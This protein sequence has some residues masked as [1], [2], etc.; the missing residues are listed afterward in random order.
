MKP[1]LSA[2]NIS[3]SLSWRQGMHNHIEVTAKRA[4]R[5]LFPQEIQHHSMT[6]TKIYRF[7]QIIESILSGVITVWFCKTLPKTARNCRQLWMSC[8]PSHKASPTSISSTSH[9]L[10]KAANII[11]DLFHPSLYLSP[12]SQQADDTKVWKN[13]TPVSAEGFRPKASPILFLE[14]LPELLSYPSI[15]SVSSI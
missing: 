3:Y 7:L 9:C 5:S 2:T 4:I 14:I 11:K 8:S 1:K 12:L 15:L 13:R 10:Q 6:F